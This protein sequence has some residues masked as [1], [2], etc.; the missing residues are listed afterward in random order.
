[1]SVK[2][3]DSTKD[4][5]EEI[6]AKRGAIALMVI[7]LLQVLIGFLVPAANGIYSIATGMHSNLISVPWWG[8]VVIAFALAVLL[9]LTYSPSR[10]FLGMQGKLRLLNSPFLIFFFAFLLVVMSLA[11]TGSP[12]WLFW[13]PAVISLGVAI[14]GAVIDYRQGGVIPVYMLGF[15]LSF[16][17]KNRENRIKTEHQAA[18]VYAKIPY[19]ARLP[20]FTK[21]GRWVI[22]PAVILVIT[23]VLAAARVVTPIYVVLGLI[24]TV[25]TGLFILVILHNLY[26]RR[27]GI[28]LDL[29]TP[30]VNDYHYLPDTV[31]ES[32]HLRWSGQ[33]VALLSGFGELAVFAICAVVWMGAVFLWTPIL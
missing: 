13:I 14:A 17:R 20:V 2:A 16:G 6:F 25:T 7:A 28:Y 32:Y 19:S 26:A 11:G 30:Y 5:A 27:T 21:A 1:M 31:R 15:K 4:P 29:P 10:H 22:A 3:A 33:K 23:V 8:F 18:E 24:G 12:Q 9:W